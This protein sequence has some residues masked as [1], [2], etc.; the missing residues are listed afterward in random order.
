MQ[1]SAAAIDIG[2]TFT[3]IVCVNPDGVLVA[4]KVLTTLPNQGIGAA[5]GLSEI[6][7]DLSAVGTV[8]HGTTAIIN[9]VLER[10]GSVTAL[11]TTAGFRDVIE[12][13]RG[14]RPRAYDI[15][16]KHPTPFVPRHLRFELDARLDALGQE[17]RPI[18]E[19]AVSEVAGKLK[20]KGVDAVAVSFINSYVDVVHEATV[21]RML[22]QLLGD[23][24]FVTTGSELSREWRE[25][26][27]TS[28]AVLNGYVG[29][30][31]KQYLGRFARELT[32]AGFGGNLELMQSNGGVFSVGDAV[33]QPIMLLESGPVAGIIGAAELG[34][35]HGHRDIL[36]FDMGGTTAKAALITDGQADIQSTYFVGGY[37]AGYPLLIP[38]VDVVEI[39]TGGGSIAWIDDLGGLAVGP[40]SAGSTPGPACYG[41]GG[42][43]ATV[44]DANLLLGRLDANN[45]LGGQI[46][47][48]SEAARQALSS[49]SYSSLG[50]D[51]VR[52]ADGVIQIATLAM[53]NAMRRVTVER[54][55]DPREF[56][57]VAYGGAGPLHA[58]ALAEELGI[59]RVIIPP[60]PGHFS[61]W[62]MLNAPTRRD[63]TR[64]RLVILNSPSVKGIVAEIAELLWQDAAE[65]VATLDGEPGVEHVAEARYQGQEHTIR[66]KLDVDDFDI[67]TFTERFEH[68][69]EKQFGHRSEG[70][71]VE[72][73]HIRLVVTV[74]F[75]VEVPS[76]SSTYESEDAGETSSRPVYYS[77]A[78]W[79]DASVV[80]RAGLEVG[81]TLDGPAIIEEHAS[82]TVV[83]PDTLVTVLHD[84]SLLLERKVD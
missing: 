21:A 69:Y 34:I 56:A 59:T 75:D 57:M 13:G 47:L 20:A 25:F 12:L 4:N 33:R 27:R 51:D 16:Y 6:Q 80:A 67:A 60:M 39:G 72:I 54:G 43:E 76:P 61:A 7:K 73:V 58:T 36:A 14:N 1:R 53:A 18:D 24:V 63:F 41:Q 52:L 40:H 62:G 78:G 38:V 82:T 15:F 19:A 83:G 8:K 84:G 66:V 2:G 68:D 29:P 49:E 26:E 50:L 71:L 23:D 79:L 28:T 65:F 48:D 45:F 30:M 10:K 22:E 64:S 46:T 3:D 77:R 74:P 55:R 5:N 35:V 11:V 32:G 9:A 42:T 81:A 70:E 44:T 37:E 31:S 17:I